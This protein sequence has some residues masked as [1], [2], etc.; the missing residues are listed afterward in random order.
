MAA[1]NDFNR[2]IIAEFRA[3]AGKVGGRFEGAPL[4]L[5]KTIGAKSGEQRITPVM[6]LADGGRMVVFASK[7]GAPTHPAWYHN[8]MANPAASVE[9]G[10]DAF[11]V[12]A[13]ATSG[14]ERDRLFNRQAELYPQFAEYREKTSREI[15]VIALERRG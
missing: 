9:V 14:E 8:L 15:P 6:Y 3:N 12:K 4:L 2:A 11:D 5:L 1:V 7:A 13:V 10:R